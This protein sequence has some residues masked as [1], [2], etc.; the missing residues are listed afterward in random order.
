MCGIFG[1]QGALSHDQILMSKCSHNIK[2][3]GPDDEG[4]WYNEESSVYLSHSRLS[5]Q[6]LSSAGHQP[7]ISEDGK[8]VL[9]Y[10][11]EIY[12]SNEI[13]SILVDEGYTF[14]GFSDTEV[15]LN[16]YRLEGVDMLSTLNG[17]F[18]FALW[19]EK[20]GGLL[21]VRDAIGVKPLY[22]S[23]L[24]GN[25][26]FSSEIKAILPSLSSD[27]CVDTKGVQQYLSFLW[28]PGERTPMS[29]IKKLLP[30]EAI[31][32]SNGS[33]D[34]K[35][36]WYQLPFFQ[37]RTIVPNK[38]KILSGVTKHLR[39][40]VERQML[41]DVPVGAFLSGGLDSSAIVAL[42]RDFQPNI[43]CFTIETCGEQD[44]GV[45]DDLPY[46]RKVA[47][48]L[49]VPLN[50]V[51]INPDRM[52]SSLET[53]VAML[54]EPLADPA[55]LN[56][57]YISQ[58]AK[59]NGIKVLLSGAGG[60]DLFTGY[61]RHHAIQLDKWLSMLPSALRTSI[62][63]HSLSLDQS[64]PLFR[65]IAKLLNGISSDGDDRIVNFFRWA[66]ESVIR[67]LFTAEA[68]KELDGIAAGQPMLDVLKQLPMDVSSLERM[69]VLEQSFFLPDHNL[70]YTDKMSMAA[71]VEV[72]VPFLDHD[73]VEFASHIPVKYKQRGRVGKWVL[74]KAMEPYLPRDV[75]YRPKTGFGAPLRRW[76]QTD[77]RDLLRDV[78]S[79]DSLRKRGIFDPQAVQRLIRNNE[80][81]VLDVSYTLF[82]L[83]CIEIWCRQFVDGQFNYEKVYGNAL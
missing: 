65:R 26:I 81:G 41:S 24:D 39:T 72:R 34:R 19:D 70:T 74:K 43:P 71:G 46:A 63:A 42:A 44:G 52:V 12:N 4:S 59:D 27:K 56:V 73:L 48:Y 13:R 7:M 2:H 28:S 79:E 60:D 45:T 9:V 61:R 82:S 64:K 29:S 8:C 50:V 78:L 38:H 35:W 55:P 32:I 20:K 14:R 53:M 17:I 37:K 66:D 77:L 83:M 67:S 11:G 76:L 36:R 1:V 6:D 10:N 75:I 68:R 22:Y 80:I 49:D 21:L 69:L 54:D 5:I 15:L 47:K 51:S 23:V 62:Q 57:L 58:L 25:V 18:S 40:A 30:G 31:W 3:R 33:I 16:L